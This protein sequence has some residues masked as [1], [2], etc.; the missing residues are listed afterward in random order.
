MAIF[1][2]QCED[3]GSQNEEIL[4]YN[5]VPSFIEE[6]SCSCG[7]SIRK[8]VSVPARMAEQ[9]AEF[10]NGVNGRFS[11]GL[12]TRVYNRKHED[13][14]LKEKGLVRESDLGR[15]FVERKIDKIESDAIAKTRKQTKVMKDLGSWYKKT[16]SW[17]KAWDKALPG[18]KILRDKEKK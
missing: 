15:D 5:D 1:E 18:K 11:P 9:W 14:I 12:G 6:H 13:K 10:P 17:E 8:V 16:G 2:F 3:C 7:G 4:H